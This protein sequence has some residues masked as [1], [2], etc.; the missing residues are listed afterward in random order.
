VQP[1]HRLTSLGALALALLAAPI[2]HATTTT[3]GSDLTATPTGLQGAGD[4]GTT[5]VQ[6]EIYTHPVTTPDGVIVRWRI[7]TAADS[8]QGTFKLRVIRPFDATQYEA[9]GT[10]SP[11]TSAPAGGTEVFDTRLPVSSGDYVGVDLAGIAVWRKTGLGADASDMAWS[12]PLPDG[13]ASAP[14]A[15]HPDEGVEYFYN[16]DVEPDADNDAFG[17][18]TQDN[19]P[20]VANVRQTNTDGAADG[21]NACDPDDDNDGRPD[22]SDNCPTTKGGSTADFDHD[23]R[24]DACD[25]PKPGACANRFAGTGKGETIV[26]SRFGDRLTGR[27]GDDI[28]KG[29]EGRDCLSGGGG[30]DLL[31]GGPGKN[32]YSG[33]GGKDRI[34]ARNGVKEKV[35][36]GSGRDTAVIDASDS[37]KHCEV[38]RSP[39]VVVAGR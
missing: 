24:G 11:H 3:I 22:S 34:V 10:S 29:L 33:G 14:D 8:N 32:R 12:P 37:V 9:V 38:V 18:D 17:D 23:G 13:D 25:A 35:D 15:L 7:K 19:C 5:F 16:A 30:G 1:R 28:L 6:T 31:R 4:D 20:G 27:G 39:I 26:G 36:C 2:A 21:G